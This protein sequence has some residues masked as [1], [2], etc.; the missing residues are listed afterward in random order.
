MKF[1]SPLRYPGGKGK[2]ADFIKLVIEKNVL[3]DGH[4]VE[5]YA[6]G[7][8]VALALLMNEYVSTIHIN[9]IDQSVYAFW[10][11][12]LN[13]TEAFCKKIMDTPIT[14][15]EWRNQKKIQK[16]LNENNITDIGFSTFF[17]NRTNRSGILKAGIIGG[18]DQSGTWKID[19]RFN[20]KELIQR[21][22]KIALYK[23]RIQLYNLDAIE[24]TKILEKKLSE[25]T[26]YYFDPPY[27]KRGEEL[28]I[29]FYNYDDHQKIAKTIGRMKKKK[30]IISYDNEPE[31]K[32]LYSRFRQN[33]YNLN[34][35]AGKSNKGQEVMIFSDVLL[36]PKIENPTKRKEIKIYKESSNIICGHI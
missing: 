27:Y 10:Y 29:N 33:I 11:A 8:S 32:K 5:P 30:W 34:Y 28:Y 9:D 12:A 18:Y 23:E 24:L 4:Y 31:I 35:C 7:A 17:L 36:I 16:S 19:A 6:G 22:E 1:Y 21:I 20:K 14:V 3:I 13:D 26:L 15:K 25:K 2:I